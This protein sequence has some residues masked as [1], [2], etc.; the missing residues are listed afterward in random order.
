MV[1]P[2]CR[3][4]PRKSDSQ[5]GKKLN[6]TLNQTIKP[7]CGNSTM[8]GC[9]PMLGQNKS[10]AHWRASVLIHNSQS[11]AHCFLN[12]ITYLLK[13]FKENFIT[14]IDVLVQTLLYRTT[15]K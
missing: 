6:I 11:I 7:A 3:G 14:H 13:H 8:G 15:L 2:K 1:T 9:T 5:T 12:N 10:G 4:I